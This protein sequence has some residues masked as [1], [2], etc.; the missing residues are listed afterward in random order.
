LED[1]F[2]VGFELSEFEGVVF[3]LLSDLGLVSFA[4]VFEFLEVRVADLFSVVV[5]LDLGGDEEAVIVV[6]AHLLGLDSELLLDPFAHAVRFA[7]APLDHTRVCG[8]RGAMFRD[9]LKHDLVVHTCPFGV[10]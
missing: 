9:D 6:F 1:C 3:S 2:R 8:E 7:S 4:L 5:M 10:T